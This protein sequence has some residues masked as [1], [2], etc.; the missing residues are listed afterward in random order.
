MPWWLSS[1]LSA[2]LLLF[3]HALWIL[4]GVSLIYYATARR[5]AEFAAGFL[6]LAA[7]CLFVSNA[8]KS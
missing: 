3:G 4:A 2:A 1:T 6:V 8:L 7:W 5:P